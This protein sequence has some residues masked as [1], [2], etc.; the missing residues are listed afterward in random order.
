[1][2]GLKTI[3]RLILIAMLCG[4]ATATSSQIS[5]APIFIGWETGDC[6][7]PG[8]SCPDY[9]PPHRLRSQNPNFQ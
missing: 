6:M 7:Y 8:G 2:F 1:M 4:L 3:K 9:I 5:S